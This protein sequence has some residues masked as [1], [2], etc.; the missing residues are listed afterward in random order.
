MKSLKIA[1]YS[2]RIPSTTFVEQLI[3]GISG[4]D[5]TIYLF[6]NKIN[7]KNYSS[8]NIITSSYSSRINKLLRL[9]WFSTMLFIFK[10][11]EKKQLD[12]WILSRNG[13]IRMHK[14]KYYPVLWYMPD[15]FHL[16]W[17]K[18]IEDWIWIQNFGIKLV[19]SLRGS[20]V[21]IEPLE[22]VELTN[23]YRKLFPK[24]DGFH[25]VSNAIAKNAVKYGAH[26]DRIKV[27]YSGLPT[28]TAENKEH[29]YAKGKDCFQ[30]LSVGRAHWVKGYHYALD[31]CK[32]LQEQHVDFHY[33]I[34]GVENAEEL[35]FQKSQLGLNNNV[36][37]L[38]SMSHDRVLDLMRKTHLLLLPSVEEG[39]ANV[40][41]EAM[42]LR[43]LVLTTNCGGMGEVVKDQINGFVIPV[44]DAKAISDK[45]IEIAALPHD[46]ILRITSNAAKTIESAH[47]IEKMVADMSALYKFVNEK[48]SV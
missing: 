43:T 19:V 32:M 17:V 18:S 12:Q 20:Q 13:N 34:V 11:K 48:L 42:S 23:L 40:L 10:N 36:T 1:I 15:V 8:K 21:N 3:D 14:I 30:I 5:V 35:Q 31:A 29:F 7:N 27:V 38:G 24:V 22:N 25:A 33:T 39:I 45:I 16:Q 41:L 2:G 6:G 46:S 44:R 9:V 37:F 26:P 47:S 4:R 28:Y